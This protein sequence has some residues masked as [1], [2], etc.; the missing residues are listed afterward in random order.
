MLRSHV[1]SKPSGLPLL[2]PLRACL[3]PILKPPYS[4]LSY[5]LINRASEPLVYA[6]CPHVTMPACP[7][8]APPRSGQPAN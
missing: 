1:P 4:I 2:P 8:G 3:S 5:R 7:L 6:P